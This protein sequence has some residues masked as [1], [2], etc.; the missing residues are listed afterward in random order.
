MSLASTGVCLAGAISCKFVGLFVVLL[1][2]GHTLFDL[3]TLLGDVRMSVPR[4]LG[5]HFAARVLCLIVLPITVYCAI[6]Y[7]HFAALPKSGTGDTF[8]SAAFQSDLLGNKFYNQTFVQ[9]RG[10]AYGSKVTIKQQS[11]AG[12]ACWLHSHAHKYPLR[13]DDQRVSSQQQQVTCY[14]HSDQNNWWIVKHPDSDSL[15]PERPPRAVLDGDVVQLVH[16]VTG[17]S[18]NSHDVASPLHAV[19]QE[20]SCYGEGDERLRREDKWRVELYDSPGAGSSGSGGAAGGV[21][22]AIDTQV[23]LQHVSTGSYL[24]VPGGRL[25]EWGFSQKQVSAAKAGSVEFSDVDTQLWHVEEN[26]NA[27][28]E[29]IKMSAT[30]ESKGFAEK[31]YEMHRVMFRSNNELTQSHPYSSRPLAWPL[32]LRGISFWQLGGPQ[33]RQVYLLG[34]PAVWWGGFFVGVLGSATL[35]IT[36]LLR[37]RRRHRDLPAS[38][39]SRLVVGASLLLC[40]WA[41]H[42]LPFFLMERQLFLH[43]YFPCLVFT[44]LLFAHVWH[45]VLAGFARSRTALLAFATAGAVLGVVT[46]YWHFAPLCYSTKMTHRHAQDM[47]WLSSW[48]IVVPPDTR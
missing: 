20:V 19:A 6:F 13:Y 25:P 48:D 29:S 31:L 46:V 44:S 12:F 47:K 7:V 24:H 26:E 4:F 36:V 33:D 30:R 35:L 11:G 34:N 21:W 40:G 15:E 39:R 18:L 17:R 10:V 16:A 5:T 23:K 45:H 38:D 43:H 41:V 28:S 27:E 14:E 2:G 42:Y 22:T 9:P 37:E 3:W 32:L 1:V 8:M